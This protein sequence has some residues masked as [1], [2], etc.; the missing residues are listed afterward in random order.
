MKKGTK[1][2]PEILCLSERRYQAFLTLFSSCFFK[3]RKITFILRIKPEKW[4]LKKK[5]SHSCYRKEGACNLF[6]VEFFVKYY[7][8][9][10]QDKHRNCCN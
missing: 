1:I 9:R 4:H 3:T 6:P 10:D 8:R 5:H 7:H 2:V